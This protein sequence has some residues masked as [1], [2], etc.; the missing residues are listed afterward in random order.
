MIEAE[1]LLLLLQSSGDKLLTPVNMF[2][3]NSVTL[4]PDLA[5][6]PVDSEQPFS[7]GIFRL[8]GIP[9]MFELLLLILGV[10]VLW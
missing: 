10:G 4:L 2:S 6:F 3:S 9:L 7:V 5:P 8:E 1:R